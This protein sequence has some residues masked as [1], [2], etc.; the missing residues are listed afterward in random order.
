MRKHNIDDD[1]I[2]VLEALYK[3]SRSAVFVDTTLTDWF[4]TTVGVKQ[5]CLLSLCL[6]NFFL[7][8]IMINALDDFTPSLKI[9]GRGISNLRFSDD[10][11]AENK[12]ELAE[13]IKRLDKAASDMGMTI[14][15]EKSKFLVTRE[16]TKQHDSENP[17]DRII[18]CKKHK[19][20]KFRNSDTWKQFSLKMVG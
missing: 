18:E 20:K 10:L 15:T 9:V 14:S 2:S 13:L 19:W 3:D 1:L 8:K 12:E 7:E 11:I 6:F 4:P 17:K 16:Q 5:G